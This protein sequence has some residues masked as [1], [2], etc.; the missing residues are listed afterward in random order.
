MS[1]ETFCSGRLKAKATIESQMILEWFSR[2]NLLSLP[3]ALVTYRHVKNWF[4]HLRD[5][6]QITSCLDSKL[7][8]IFMNQKFQF[9]IFTLA[10]DSFAV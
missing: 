8:L 4:T 10:I 7:F 9:M 5:R 6:S 1:F 3:F 2:D